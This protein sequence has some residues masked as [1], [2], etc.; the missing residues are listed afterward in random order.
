MLYTILSI[1][2]D[3]VLTLSA[4]YTG[5][6]AATT[7]LIREDTNSDVIRVEDVAEGARVCG[8][9][10]TGGSRGIVVV[11]CTDASIEDNDVRGAA[12]DGIE[13]TTC[14]RPKV[15]RNKAH[16]NGKTTASKA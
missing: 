9:I 10:V 12:T 2:N 4:I 15:N 6:T 16:N 1:I 11:N 7:T 5:A 8:N 3:T 14:T 13:V